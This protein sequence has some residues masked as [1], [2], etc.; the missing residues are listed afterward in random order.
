[1]LEVEKTPFSMIPALSHALIKPPAGK[2]AIASRI[3]P[4][5]ILSNDRAS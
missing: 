1:M 4:W 5:L 3:T 2:L